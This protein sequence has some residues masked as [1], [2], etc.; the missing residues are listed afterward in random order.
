MSTPDSRLT[1]AERAALAS[2]EAAAAAEDPHLATRLKGSPVS[3]VKTVPPIAYSYLRGRWRTLLRLRWWGVPITVA[4]LVLVVLGMSIGTLLSVTGAAVCAVGL[5][6][7]AQM[8][9]DRRAKA[10]AP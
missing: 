6:V 2:L 5:R 4:G 8:I 7:L 9:E 10:P 1:A 3:R